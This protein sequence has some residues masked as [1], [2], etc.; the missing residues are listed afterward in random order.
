MGRTLDSTTSKKARLEAIRDKWFREPLQAKFPPLTD[1]DAHAPNT[2]DEFVRSNRL[3]AA[4]S[5]LQLAPNA[6]GM[7]KEEALQHDREL[8]TERYGIDD[9][10]ALLQRLSRQFDQAP[11]GK[12]DPKSLKQ[13]FALL[14]S[15]RRNSAELAA[16]LPGDDE[17]SG[18]LRA[19]HR[20]DAHA[21]TQA[22]ALVQQLAAEVGVALPLNRRGGRNR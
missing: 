20:A 15:L 13:A 18:A 3:M 11:C 8:N 1:S 6:A 4:F 14:D 12:I 16:Q 10:V 17:T 19:A 5:T 9:P 22:Q 21:I 2:Y 7:S